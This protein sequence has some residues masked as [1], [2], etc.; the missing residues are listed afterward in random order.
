MEMVMKSLEMAV[1]IDGDGSGVDGDGSGGTSPSR[2]GAGTE[3]YVPR[4]WLPDGGDYESFS[5]K[6]PGVLG[7]S[8]ARLFIGERA[9]SGGGQGH[10]TCPWRGQGLAAPWGVWIGPG[11]PPDSL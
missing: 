11:P 5:G 2:Q 4:T 6:L 7:F 3:T 1:E 8:F 10:H 9:E